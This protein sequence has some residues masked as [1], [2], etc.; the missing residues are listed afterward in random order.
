MWN[1]VYWSVDRCAHIHDLVRRFGGPRDQGLRIFVWG[2]SAH[3]LLSVFSYPRTIYRKTVFES[4]IPKSR[5]RN[6]LIGLFCPHDPS[7]CPPFARKL[8]KIPY[9]SQN[10][11]RNSDSN[12]GGTGF[13]SRRGGELYR[14]A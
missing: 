10:S 14:G 7:V 3:P 4:G 12:R 5:K 2:I 6:D 13:E 11:T 9:L 8:V 1:A